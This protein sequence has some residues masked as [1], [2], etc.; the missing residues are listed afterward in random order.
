MICD[1]IRRGSS[2]SKSVFIFFRCIP[3]VMCER[4]VKDYGVIWHDIRTMSHTWRRVLIPGHCVFDLGAS[5]A[6]YSALSSHLIHERPSP[7]IFMRAQKNAIEREGMQRAHVL[8]GA[9]MCE[10]LSALDRRVI[11]ATHNFVPLL[12]Y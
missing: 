4:R 8:D 11:H 5:E 2:H 7:I 1:E 9:A 10:A 3:F 6:I 12:V